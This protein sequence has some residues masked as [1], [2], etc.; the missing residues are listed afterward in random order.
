[1]SGRNKRTSDAELSVL[2]RPQ[3]ANTIGT[4]FG[5]RLLEWMD[6]AAAICARR[7]TALR[8]ATVSL[9]GVQFL[10]PIRVGQVMDFRACVNRTF[11]TSLEVQVVVFA[12]DTYRRKR[13]L[14]VI[15]YFT[16]VGLDENGTP[17]A[18]PIFEPQTDNEIERWRAAELRR[19]QAADAEAPIFDA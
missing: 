15:G 8:V 4:I 11:G 14:A 2:A 1:M 3:D 13:E 12:Q 16:L 5:G 6:M 9:T 10:Q 7:H 19:S 18:V 17:V